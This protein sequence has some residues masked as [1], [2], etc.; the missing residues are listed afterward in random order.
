MRNALSFY[1]NVLRVQNQVP[2]QIT[3]AKPAVTMKQHLRSRSHARLIWSIFILLAML[4]SYITCINRPDT[5]LES[6]IISV[7]LAL[8]T[9]IRQRRCPT[10]YRPASPMCAKLRKFMN[11]VTNRPYTNSHPTNVVTVLE[12]NKHAESRL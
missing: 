5:W 12:L 1:L 7:S 10:L 9:G 8:V 3:D 11:K 6:H 4:G 2:C